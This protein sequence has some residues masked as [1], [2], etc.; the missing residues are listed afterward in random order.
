MGKFQQ[1][2]ISRKSF[3][4]LTGVTGLAGILPGRLFHSLTYLHPW[5]AFSLQHFPTR[6]Q[7]ILSLVPELFADACG[8]L[9]LKNG[10]DGLAQPIPIALTQWNLEHSHPWDGL[11]QGYPWAIVLHWY[12][13]KPGFDQSIPGYLRGFDEIRKIADYFTRTSAHFL[14]GQ[15]QP[16]LPDDSGEPI[17]IIQ[18]Q[19][20]NLDGIPFVDEDDHALHL[21]QD[22]ARHV[23]VL[24]RKRLGGIY[25]EQGHVRAVDGLKRA[26]NAPLLHAG[27]NVAAPPHTSG[28]N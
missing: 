28:V 23:R 3:L 20:P 21:V 14:V 27:V 10:Q 4:Q 18:T 6:I 1:P 15:G 9:H 22:E 7:Q 26:Q 16:G 11:E 13:D 2:A 8:Y 5:P 24:L 17:S 12:G 19:A 25:H